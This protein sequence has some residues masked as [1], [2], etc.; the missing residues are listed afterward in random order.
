MDAILVRC[1]QCKHAM[2]FSA[3]K[4]GKKAKCPKC[5][6]IVVVQA[7]ESA[8]EEPVAE[9]PAAAPAAGAIPNREQFARAGS[10]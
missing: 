7:D 9:A 10:N 2:K 3:E 5:E 8:P 6:A 4:A 1:T